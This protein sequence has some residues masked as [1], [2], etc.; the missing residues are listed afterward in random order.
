MHIL[1]L[2]IYVTTKPLDTI[3]IKII[4]IDKNYI[5]LSPARNEKSMFRSNLLIFIDF[6]PSNNIYRPA[7]FG[8]FDF[9]HF[10][11]SQRQDSK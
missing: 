5:D 3:N 6:S 1:R 4:A 11:E 2:V 8:P 10:N 7:V 9:R